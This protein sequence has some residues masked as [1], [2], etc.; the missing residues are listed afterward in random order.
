[1]RALIGTCLFSFQASLNILMA[2]PI[3]PPDCSDCMKDCTAVRRPL[4]VMGKLGL[5]GYFFL[6]MANLQ[7]N[8]AEQAV[9]AQAAL[10]RG[11]CVAAAVRTLNP[12]PGWQH[13]N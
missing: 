11:V 7:R 2:L 8:S 10:A 4:T 1:M 6:I 12:A 5:M 13:R 9:A 3:P